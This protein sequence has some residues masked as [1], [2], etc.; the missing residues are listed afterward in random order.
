MGLTRKHFGTLSDGQD[1]S[2][3]CLSTGDFEAGISS[4]GATWLS[5]LVPSAVGGRRRDD[6]LLGFSGLDGYTRNE[7]FFGATIGR[8]ANR[9]AGA[10]FSLR[11]RE[12]RLTPNDGVN[13]LHGGRRGFDK[14][15]W[16]EKWIRSGNEPAVCLQLESPNGDEGFPGNM[17]IEAVF[18]LSSSGTFTIAYTAQ[19]D[20]PTPLCM[21]NHAY[22]NLS[23]EGS[24][25]ILGHEVKLLCEKYLPCT[26]DHIPLQSG[27]APVKGTPFD[28]LAFKPVGKDVGGVDGGYDHCFIKE[29]GLDDDF[30][31]AFIRD[32]ATDRTL[33]IATSLPA[34]QFYTGNSLAGE[35]G[36][37][38][39]VY[40]QHAGFCIEPEYYPDSPNRPD[41]PSCL[42]EPG[43]T[44]EAKT[45]YSFGL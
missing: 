17:K 28:F 18:S 38:G 27:P 14:H 3:Y 19:T 39:S 8:Y 31:V 36:K 10:R 2:I 1:V 29:A 45:I 5:F 44:W 15:V 40:R 21:T 37:R 24:G 12:Y 25:D 7:P 4:Y 11:G 34:V 16:M 41:F 9:I 26:A 30:P 33:S 6:L 43:K 22:F 32:P 20:A 13:L 42:L 35:R 23:G